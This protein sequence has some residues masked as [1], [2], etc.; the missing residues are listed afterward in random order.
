[1][2]KLDSEH[3]R[4]LGCNAVHFA[5]FEFP[6][7]AIFFLILKRSP[8]SKSFQHAHEFSS[9][10]SRQLMG[11][12]VLKNNHKLIR[13]LR[14]EHG[15]PSH[16]GNKVWNS[17]MVLMDYLRQKPPRR[18][19]QVLEVGCGWAIAAIYCAKRWR[20]QVSGLDIDKS[21]LPFAQLHAEINKTAIDTHAK[22]FQRASGAFL[23]SFDL[24]IGA[25]I[26][27]WDDMSRPLYNLVKRASGAG[28][29]V[30]L[31]DPGRA[32]FMALAERAV[33]SLNGELQAHAI[34]D[35]L[36]TSSWVL[37]VPG[38]K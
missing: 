30:V 37:D 14:A 20:C 10:N 2:A 9:H 22:S 29:R 15:Y 6:R 5:A 8:V 16:H 18:R 35:P 24:V 32:P 17:S 34:V 11:L 12:R 38:Q 13:R 26:C 31:A 27:F 23:Q 33:A 28:A 36:Q 7:L 1:M 21:V 4:P 3:F 19:C 25:D